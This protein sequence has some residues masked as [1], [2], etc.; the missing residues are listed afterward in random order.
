MSNPLEDIDVDFDPTDQDQLLENHEE[1]QQEP[2]QDGKEPDEPTWLD[3]AEWVGSNQEADVLIYTTRTI[4]RPVE[5]FRKQVR[6]RTLP[7]D[8]ETET[9]AVL[10]LATQGGSPHC[11]YRLARMLKRKYDRLTLLLYG[12]CKSAGTLIALGADEIHMGPMSELGPLD[13][14]KIQ[15]DELLL[16]TSVLDIQQ[17]LD[18]INGKAFRFYQQFMISIVSHFEGAISTSTA[19]DIA[20]R[21]AAALFEPVTSQID[22]LRLGEDERKMMVAQEYGE[23]LTNDKEAVQKLIGGYPSHSFVIDLEEAEQILGDKTVQQLSPLEK[24]LGRLGQDFLRVETDPPMAKYLYLHDHDTDAQS[25][26]ADSEEETDS[27]QQVQ[28]GASDEDVPES[29]QH[30]EPEAGAEEARESE[31]EA[32]SGVEHKQDGEAEGGPEEE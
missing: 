19:S 23:R 25:D 21:M 13:M 5:V 26:H 27:D 17:A 12:S 11:A 6:Q 31:V 20:A 29:T 18:A 10:I 8:S 32:E 14:Q 2:D 4:Q 1:K 3:A 24:I 28:S 9:R 7:Q 15:E 30:Q 16:R 22:P